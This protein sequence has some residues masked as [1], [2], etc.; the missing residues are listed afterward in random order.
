MISTV[1]FVG[2]L[3]LGG[4]LVYMAIGP[5]LERFA[6][7]RVRR[8]QAG[9]GP[10][11]TRQTLFPLGGAI[12]FALIYPGVLLKLYFLAAG[13]L[14]TYFLVQ[15][16]R[17]A[18]EVIQPRQIVQL[19]LSF[20]SIYQLQPSVFSSLQMVTQKL[21]EPLRGL[22][23]VMTQTYYL[24]SSPQRAF[25]EFRRRTDSIYL[26]QFIYILEM[27]ESATPGAMTSALD[28]FVDRMRGHDELRRETETSLSSVTGQTRFMQILSLLVILVVG[29]VPSLRRAYRGLGM[30]AV[31]MIIMS[32]ALATSWYIERRVG[33]LKERIQ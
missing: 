30:Q 2:M 27:G 13:A 25:A 3:A 29:V 33:A 18:A 7:P 24:T 17:M 26:H 21:E 10:H 11:L 20:R 31:F 16:R 14:V 32:V 19:V 6:R 28:S 8:L 15:Q 1:L 4:L 12:V 22:V 23:E 9:I 5:Q